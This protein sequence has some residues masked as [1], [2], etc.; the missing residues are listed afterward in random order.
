MKKSGHGT[1]FWRTRSF[2]KI[3]VMTK[4][5]LLLICAVTLQSIAGGYSQKINLKADKTTIKKVLKAIQLQT[6]FRFVYRD[7]LLPDDHLVSANFEN[8]GITAVLD[9][10]LA[11]TNLTYSKVG[12]SLFVLVTTGEKEENLLLYGK[13][14]PPSIKGK[15]T[16]DKGEPV[17]GATV[18]E[19][20]T[21]NGTATKEDGG[22][23]LDVVGANA[24]L[25]VSSVG[26]T[27]Q[28]ITVGSKTSIDIILKLADNALNEV[29]VVGYG[30]QSK[31]KVTGAVSTLDGDEI[32]K[33]PV[34]N[35]T[36]SLAGRIPGL[37]SLNTSGH[38]GTGSSISIR[39]VSSYNNADPL[40]VID[41]TVRAV[42]NFSELDP[43]DIESISVLKDAGSA[44]VYGVRA[45]N[46]VIVVTT[47]RGKLGKPVFSLGSSVSFDKPTRYPKVMDGYQ[48]AAY[49]KAA[50][51]NMGGTPL[52]TDQQIEDFRTGKT[53]STNWQKESF[54]DNA[55]T[56]MNNLNVSG[57]TEA[58]KYFF[59]FGYT[60]QN[61]I[62]PN[63]GYTRYNFRTNL[64]IKLNKTL[65]ATVNL[66]GKYS[67]N[68]SPNISD[69]AIWTYASGL[70]SS[71][72]AYNSD[73]SFHYDP[74]MPQHPVAATRGTGY[75]KLF[76]NLFVGGVT[77]AQQLPFVKGLTAKGSIQVWRQY[78]FGKV[79][80]L[81]YNLYDSAGGAPHTLNGQTALSEATNTYNTYT[82]DLSLD[83]ARSFGN[84]SV[85][86]LILYEQYAQKG[87]NLSAY[88]TNYILNTIDQLFAG[89]TDNTLNNNGSAS[90]DGRLSVV[91]RLNYDYDSKYLFEASFR[92][93]ASWRFAPDRR[94]GVFPSFSAGWV[95]S[96]EN[97]LKDKKWID[98]LKI[99]GSWGILG[100][101]NVGGFQ[102]L[103][104]YSLQTSPYFFGPTTT[105]QPQIVPGV[106]PNPN[107]TW[108]STS[109]T[110][111]GVDATFLHK[112]IG[113]SFDVFQ[114]NTYDMYLGRL[115]QYP[116]VYG[117]SIPSQNYGKM[118]VRGWEL[119]LTHENK[120]GQFRY[121][122]NGNASFSRNRV[123]QVDFTPNPYPWNNPIDKPVNY[124]TGYI[125][126]G[127]FQSDKEA[128]AAPRIQGTNPKAGDI[129]Y[130]DLNHDGIIDPRDQAILS[131]NAGTP[132]VMYGLTLDASWKG[133][134]FN[135]FFQGVANRDLMFTDYSRNG[136]MNGNSF[137][138]F[139]DYWSPS[140]T[141]A[142][143][144]R[145][146]TGRSSTTDVNSSYWLHSGAFC[147][148]KN[149]QIAYNLPRSVIQPIKLSAVR[150]YISGTNLAIFS[151]IK[152]FD[153]EMAAN[154]GPGTG[155]YYP[156][157][158][159]MIIGAN[160][161]F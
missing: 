84:H 20:G 66:E 157:N 43:N 36:Q 158:K 39:G 105:P 4:L 132:E 140:N 129:S 77:L 89:A 98:F 12:D 149:V 103:S 111:I 124:Y 148:L 134:S 92:N 7:D 53:P 143:Y 26:Y 110:N 27:T 113:V 93:D 13:Y 37:I 72:P 17:A 137:A 97:F 115:N 101:D 88:R 161:S 78:N 31:A 95:A 120:I 1:P 96:K 141:D 45:T 91:G 139:M 6:P 100:N 56:S 104:S 150:F 114:K 71:I 131:W 121:G 144:P 135:I 51:I 30:T 128:A 50:S 90:Q 151:S 8:S 145:A 49:Q 123:K 76:D 102:Y 29:V 125:S 153:P 159:S 122:I 54:G 18:L 21:T 81:P 86:A 35:N 62:Y 52:Y 112:L 19:K 130:Q 16:N 64:D 2:I 154:A 61:G 68:F 42:N 60:N 9:K 155:F 75:N 146:W 70:P 108:E 34:T 107:L 80:N 11:N 44:A 41:G 10:V 57:G 32:R 40:Y 69:Y 118:N 3:L 133:F 24:I 127:L 63:V 65:T 147:R 59:S 15:V 109:E 82:L 14:L 117:A 46:G 116:G 119:S 94:W 73:G 83:Y 156:Q 67:N 38:P 87:D 142:K 22:F 55:V 74:I 152:D 138:Y 126:N 99:R 106:V 23:A 85:K 28:E 48:Y 47:R 136:L 160:I 58:I 33:M 79:W 25:V 5:T